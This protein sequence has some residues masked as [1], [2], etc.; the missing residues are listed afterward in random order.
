[1][2]SQ[3][4]IKAL[5]IF[6]INIRM[7]TVRAMGTLGFGHLGGALSIAD[8]IA[9]LYGGAMKIDPKNPKWEDRDWLVSSKGHAGPAIYAAL[10]LKG[11]FPVEELLTLNKPGTHF[12][13]HCDRNLT[14]GIDMTTGSLGQGASTSVGVALGHKYQK[15]NNYTYLILGDGETQEGQVWEAVSFAGARKLDNL[16]AFVDNNKQQLDGFTRNIHDTLDFKAKFESFGWHAIDVDGSDVVQIYEA[17]EAAKLEKGKPTV[18]VLDTVKGKGVSFVEGKEKNHHVEISKEQ[19]AQGLAE[20]Q[21]ELDKE[22][23]A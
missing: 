6:A 16:I 8:T 19:M 17:I 23:E 10:A 15:K 11:Y 2:L 5:K 22:V 14:T 20:L 12:P 21:L 13:S 7:E 9:V 3:E 4:K 1:M 18:I